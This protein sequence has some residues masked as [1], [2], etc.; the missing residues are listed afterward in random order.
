MGIEN[1]NCFFNPKTIAVIGAS[2][3]KT[4]LGG[5]IF[6]NLLGTYQGLVFPVNEFRQTVQGVKAYPSISKVPSKI[7]LAIVAT[8]AH[9]IPQIVEECGKAECQ[10]LLLCLQVLTNATR[11]G[12]NL[13]RQIIERSLRYGTRI[14]GPNSLGVIRPKNNL[15][16]TF[17]DK[18]AVL[19]KSLS[20][21]KVPH[22]AE[23]F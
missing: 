13:T 12:Q 1:L 3:R 4:S 2:E 17:G 18:K 19:E 7:D 9:T 8:P 22:C 14:I 11:V 5:L 20:F 15:Y 10:A 6:R 23:Q 16:A 21:P